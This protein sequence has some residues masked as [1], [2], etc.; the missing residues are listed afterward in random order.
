MLLGYFG[1]WDLSLELSNLT[2]L[3]SVLFFKMVDLILQQLSI[4]KRPWE[5]ELFELLFSL[6]EHHLCVL[7]LEISL[8][9][10]F[11]FA[12]PMGWFASVALG[13]GVFRSDDWVGLLWLWIVVIVIVVV[14]VG[15]ASDRKDKMKLACSIDRLDSKLPLW[16]L[17]PVALPMKILVALWSIHFFIVDLKISSIIRLLIV[18]RH[19]F[20]KTRDTSNMLLFKRALVGQLVDDFLFVDF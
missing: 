6:S 15:V 20:V 19:G 9:V 7:L 12:L 16:L 2:S 11:A 18:R 4:V 8:D 3:S 5:V 13:S 17:V 14:R 10:L 1:Y